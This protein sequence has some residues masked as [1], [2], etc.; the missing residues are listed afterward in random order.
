[1][2]ASGKKLS[3]AIEKA[4]EGQWHGWGRWARGQ[5]ADGTRLERALEKATP[6]LV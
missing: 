3:R 2:T 6:Q 5:R 4:K 1:M